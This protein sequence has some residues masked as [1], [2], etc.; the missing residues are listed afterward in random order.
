MAA[1]RFGLAGG[2]RRMR[3]SLQFRIP[4]GEMAILSILISLLVSAAAPEAQQGKSAVW[5]SAAAQLYSAKK[6]FISNVNQDA[7]ETWLLGRPFDLGERQPYN[8]LYAAMQSWGRY[9]VVLEPADADLVLEIR[10]LDPFDYAAQNSHRPIALPSQTVY[11]PQLFL[12]VRDARTHEVLK[13]FTEPI[14]K[15]ILPS[16]QEKNFAQAVVDLVN[17]IAKTIRQ[18]IKTF[19]LPKTIPAAPLPTQIR[20]AKKLLISKPEEDRVHGDPAKEEQLYE[21]VA[22]ATENLAQYELTTT[23][24]DAD[25]IWE[26]SV[27]DGNLRLA[28]VDP[29]TGTLLWAINEEVDRTILGTTT[30]E[31]FDRATVALLNNAGQLA[32]KAPFA[33]GPAFGRFISASTG[34]ALPITITGPATAKAGAEIRIQVTVKN[35]A[36]FDIRFDY[37]WGDPL[38]CMVV[39]R[40]SGGNMV[41]DTERGRNLKSEHADWQG[42]AVSYALNPGESQTR[43]CAVSDLYDMST[44]GKYVIEVQQLDGR[45]VKSNVLTMTVVR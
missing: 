39:V 11:H 43:E 15:A 1:A 45:P 14:Q 42:Q 21:E 35:T 29:K 40:D 25:L 20:T 41:A 17:D 34:A 7:N 16:N 18:P 22:A 28:I 38:R 27:Y 9:E 2:F 6:V 4:E 31:H 30:Q 36:H 5:G 26:P 37:A 12:T 19:T 44:P 33:E 13:D 3:K 10:Y 23:A 32:G 8:Y 24:E